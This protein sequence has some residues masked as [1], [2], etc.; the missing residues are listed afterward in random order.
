MYLEFNRALPRQMYG[1]NRIGTFTQ[2]AFRELYRYICIR[3]GKKI[4]HIYTGELYISTTRYHKDFFGQYIKIEDMKFTPC[5][6]SGDSQ[7][8][9][10][11]LCATRWTRIYHDAVCLFHTKYILCDFC[12]VINMKGFHRIWH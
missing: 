6:A 5:L 8:F 4:F 9:F 1:G 3:T 12:P 2:R 10:S 7:T 11:I